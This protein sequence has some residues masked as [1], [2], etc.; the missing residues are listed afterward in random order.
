[1]GTYDLEASRKTTTDRIGGGNEEAGGRIYNKK[2]EKVNKSNSKLVNNSNLAK[3]TSWKKIAPVAMLNQRKKD[4]IMRKRKSP[5]EENKICYIKVVYEDG[6]KRLKCKE[7]EDRGEA[8]L[9]MVIENMEQS[10]V[11][12]FIGLAATKRQA[13]RTQ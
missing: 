7:K 4:S 1:M 10:D 9:S 8:L 3:K 5:K 11:P 6:A 2:V 12:N 13:H